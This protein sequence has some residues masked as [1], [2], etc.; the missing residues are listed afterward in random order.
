MGSVRALTS[1]I[2]T[3]KNGGESFSCFHWMNVL[4]WKGANKFARKL[5]ILLRREEHP[6]PNCYQVQQRTLSDISRNERPSI[7]YF[8][9][10]NATIDSK[11]WECSQILLHRLPLMQLQLRILLHDNHPVISHD[12]IHHQDSFF[13]SVYRQT[14]LSCFLFVLF[15]V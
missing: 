15:G 6:S 1:V 13:T 3:K 2:G 7:G 10:I 5:I 9:N 12:L 14:Y 11:I 8:S 4:S